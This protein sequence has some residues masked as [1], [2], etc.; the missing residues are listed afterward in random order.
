MLLYVNLMC[1]EHQKHIT[2]KDMTCA[3]YQ[4]LS[5]K[6]QTLLPNVYLKPAP[7]FELDICAVKKS[8]LLLEI[9]IK[10]SRENFKQD[11]RKADIQHGN[12]HRAL[13]EGR[14]P[15]NYFSFLLPDYLLQECSIPPYCGLYIAHWNK[16]GDKLLV[17]ERRLP[18]LLHKQTLTPNQINDIRSKSYDR[19]WNLYQEQS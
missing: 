2:A 6:F 1:M 10:V 13:R 12:K 15:P 19:M 18:K 8:R 16:A 4:Q 17:S 9:E 14:L 3:F 11:L 5:S 7:A